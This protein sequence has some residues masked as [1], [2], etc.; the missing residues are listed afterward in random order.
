MIIHNVVSKRMFQK[1]PCFDYTSHDFPWKILYKKFVS[2][3]SILYNP[4][5][6][7]ISLARQEF[8]TLPLT[9]SPLH[10]KGETLPTFYG[11]SR[12]IPII[13]MQHL[14]RLT[15]YNIA[16]RLCLLLKPK[17]VNLYL[18]ILYTTS[19]C[20]AFKIVGLY[21]RCFD[22][23]VADWSIFSNISRFAFQDLVA[24]PTLFFV[25]SSLMSGGRT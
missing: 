20:L 7:S 12:T 2:F 24:L 25:P 16:I 15:M 4:W 11:L 18:E 19:A 21:N 23:P 5:I 17:T 22:D 14:C 9:T 10:K 3:V 1:Q 6:L 13:Y 8:S